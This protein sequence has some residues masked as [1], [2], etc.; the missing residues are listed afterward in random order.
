MLYKVAADVFIDEAFVV[1]AEFNMF[2]DGVGSADTE[3]VGVPDI[4]VVNVPAPEI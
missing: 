2:G 3:T 1:A 4:E